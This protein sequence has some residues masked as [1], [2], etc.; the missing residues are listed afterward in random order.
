MP[1]N[2][3]RTIW[4]IVLQYLNKARQAGKSPIIDRMAVGRRRLKIIPDVEHYKHARFVGQEKQN[5]ITKDRV[6][7]VVM[8]WGWNAVIMRPLLASILSR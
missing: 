5:A 1:E 3:H 2:V 4:Q 6:V 7:G 8:H